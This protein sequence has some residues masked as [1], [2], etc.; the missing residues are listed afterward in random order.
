M[1]NKMKI[2]NKKLFCLLARTEGFWQKLFLFNNVHDSLRPMTSSLRVFVFIIL[3]AF[4][5]FSGCDL[6]AK[7]SS[8]LALKMI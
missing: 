7:V 5:I 1:M 6:S 4:V 3:K 2:V 8:K